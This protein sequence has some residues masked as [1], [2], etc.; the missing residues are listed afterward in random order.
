MGDILDR[1]FTSIDLC[2]HVLYILEDDFGVL[3]WI[4]YVE[5][6]FFGVNCSLSEC[7][8][9]SKLERRVIKPGIALDREDG[10]VAE[11]VEAVRWPVYHSDDIS[12][13][14]FVTAAVDDGVLPKAALRHCRG[15]QGKREVL[16]LIEVARHE[17]VLPERLSQDVV[18]AVKLLLILLRLFLFLFCFFLI[19]F[20]V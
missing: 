16:R 14:L 17:H 20:C 13:V 5:P 4:L 19:V 3:T 15:R 8:L 7:G 10:E 18:V 6:C 11:M 9:D 1:S 12:V 2:R